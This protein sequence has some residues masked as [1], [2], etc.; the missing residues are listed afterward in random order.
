MHNSGVSHMDKDVGRPDTDWRTS[1]QT[2]LS[3]H[4][5]SIIK[6]IDHRVANLTRV[7]LD[8]QEQVR[9]GDQ[10]KLCEERPENVYDVFIIR[11]RYNVQES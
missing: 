4:D 11:C 2:W 10:S 9:E 1:T 6:N 8:H 7:P 5:S 3:S